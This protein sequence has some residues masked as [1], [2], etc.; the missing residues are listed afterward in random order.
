MLYKGNATEIGQ[1]I[2]ALNTEKHWFLRWDTGWWGSEGWNLIVKPAGPGMA[3][4]RLEGKP[5]TP[6]PSWWSPLETWLDT[7]FGRVVVGEDGTPEEVIPKRPGK[8]K[9]PTEETIRRAH[10]Y[11][12][13]KNAHPEWSYS[14]VAMEANRQEPDAES[15]HTGEGVRNAYRDMRATGAMGWTWKRGDRGR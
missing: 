1:L 13:L 3:Q 8:I 4:V 5:D 11:K 10:L 7:T 12:G 15:A 14:K 9:G 2:N 6:L